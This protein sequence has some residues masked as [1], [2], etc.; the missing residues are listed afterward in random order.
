MN[1]TPDPRRWRMLLACSLLTI[2]VLAVPSM[3][4][5]WQPGTPRLF[6][7]NDLTF[8]LA[9]TVPVLLFAAVAL[10]GG[11]LADLTG[12]RRVLVVGVVLFV[13]GLLVAMTARGELQ[14]I[15]GRLTGAVGGGL[16]APIA[17]GLVRAG[18]PD[19]E[20]ARALGIFTAVQGTGLIGGPIVASSI[21]AAFTWRA[22]HVLPLLATVLGG[23][24]A[25]SS[26]PRTPRHPPTFTGLLVELGSWWLILLAAI[27]GV[28][29]LTLGNYTLSYETVAII[30]AVL[31]AAGLL[32]LR[33]I[34]KRSTEPAR[35][36]ALTTSV[37]SGTILFAAFI[38]AFLQLNGFLGQA[39]QAASGTRLLQL[40]PLAPAILVG[41][42]LL[43]RRGASLG[44]RGR[45]VLAFG[46]MALGAGALSLAQPDTSYLWLLVPILALGAGFS[47]GLLRMNEM[48]LGMLPATLAASAAAMAATAGR[49]GAGL[50][51]ILAAQ[52]LLGVSN[53]D[54]SARLQA[55]GVDASQVTTVTD[56]L[57]KALA[58]TTL[59]GG[60]AEPHT[61]LGALLDLYTQAYTT[62]FAWTMRGVALVCLLGAAVVWIGLSSAAAR[63][64]ARPAVGGEPN[65]VKEA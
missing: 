65:I 61:T 24:V 32:W 55:G 49:V 47:L 41:G 48:I 1:V 39:Q 45:G 53:A 63:A 22:A 64:A 42:V 10:V 27:F 54:L 9:T 3:S 58:Q 25:W 17:M 31:G 34:G 60:T 23:L 26:I 57:A 36:I 4:L 29:V 12:R 44:P 6:G 7:A 40:L 50:G 52:T 35:L 8:K 18:F 46:L 56:A 16:I 15:V 20:R 59:G 30:V 33:R 38:A 51:Q 28:G 14:V 13:G 5:A 21:A 19:D 11:V 2:A 62:G 43:T 37:V